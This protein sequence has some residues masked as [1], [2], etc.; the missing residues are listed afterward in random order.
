M[1]PLLVREPE[2]R[3]LLGN[4]SRETLWKLRRAGQV[5]SISI[6]TARLY[7][8]DSLRHYVERAKAE[9]GLILAAPRT[10]AGTAS[11]SGPDGRPAA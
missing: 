5:E 4:V 6:G 3:Q 10:P 2:A 8:V 11:A 1:E 7:P 9:G